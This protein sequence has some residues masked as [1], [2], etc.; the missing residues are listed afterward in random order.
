MFGIGPHEVDVLAEKDGKRLTAV[1]CGVKKRTLL[2]RCQADMRDCCGDHW[3][4]L[5]LL[6]GQV[7]RN[8]AEPT[9]K[10]VLRHRFHTDSCYPA[11]D[12]GTGPSCQGR[13]RPP[14]R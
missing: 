11:C 13:A 9:D 2:G 10:A 5:N 3:A 4:N 1:D 7:T 6:G 8:E 14:Q 12:G